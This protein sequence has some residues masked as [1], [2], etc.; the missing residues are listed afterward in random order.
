MNREKRKRQLQV[1]AHL[2]RLETRWLMRATPVLAVPAQPLEAVREHSEARTQA[3]VVRLSAEI[4]QQPNHQSRAASQF[5][6]KEQ[7]AEL[8]QVVPSNMSWGTL[9]VL[10]PRGPRRPS[11]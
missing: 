3:L 4:E 10:A 9:R 5:D 8:R 1:K 2:E 11:V 6:L 7:K